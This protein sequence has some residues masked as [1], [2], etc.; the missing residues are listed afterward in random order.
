LK[1]LENS[2]GETPVPQFH[3]RL[4]SASDDRRPSHMSHLASTTLH[5]QFLKYPGKWYAALLLLAMSGCMPLTGGVAEINGEAAS[6]GAAVAA[7]DEGPINGGDSDEIVDD[8]EA[9]HDVND[10]AV[11]EDSIF[12][13]RPER[14][15]VELE[16]LRIEAPAGVFGE[17]AAVWEIP[18]A[19]FPNASRLLQL[20]A[21]GFLV[22][23]GRDSDRTELVQFLGNIPKPAIAKDRVQPDATRLVDVEI[24][25][26]KGIVKLFYFDESGSLRGME[27]E[28]PVV[29]FKLRVEFRSS[30]LRDIWLELMPELE[31]PPGPAKWVIGP[32]ER[33]RQ[34][35]Q[36]RKHA[37][38]SLAFGAEIPEGGFLML[39][40]TTAVFEQPLLARPFFLTSKSSE[41]EDRLRFRDSLYVIRPIVRTEAV[42][43]ET[44]VEAE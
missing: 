40:S 18:R 8:A 19:P 31:E 20:R 28:D 39:G 14:L 16:V 35:A 33:A 24:G 26:Q 6:N 15:V 43:V 44:A 21:N 11:T 29:R 4:L 2:T 25:E 30:N 7:T 32:D 17:D 23:I 38:A 1:V 37:F 12:A 10:D 41:T 5:A 22:A 34:V 9:D 36:E 42:G 13:R 27:V 3:H